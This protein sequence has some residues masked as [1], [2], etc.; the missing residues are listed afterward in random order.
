MPIFA[1]NL[2]LLIELGYM[3]EGEKAVQVDI[4][5]YL[6]IYDTFLKEMRLFIMI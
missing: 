4:A 1:K 3:L 5:C 6:E 2:G